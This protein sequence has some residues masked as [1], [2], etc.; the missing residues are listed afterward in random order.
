[1]L[2]QYCHNAPTMLP[3]C[4]QV[5]DSGYGIPN[6][7]ALTQILQSQPQALVDR[8][9]NNISRPPVWSISYYGLSLRQPS[10]P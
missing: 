9:V 4:C 3:Q 2:P 5:Y 8:L 7:L 1:M 6:N 10:N